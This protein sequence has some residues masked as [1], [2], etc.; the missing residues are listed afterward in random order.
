MTP[1]NHLEESDPL[2]SLSELRR[3]REIVY[4][5]GDDKALRQAAY[6]TQEKVS[7][8]IDRGIEK[9]QKM[10]AD[11]TAQ[12]E[13]N[14]RSE[15]VSLLEFIDQRVKECMEKGESFDVLDVGCGRG[16]FLLELHA[17][18]VGKYGEEVKKTLKFTGLSISDLRNSYFDANRKR[19][20]KSLLDKA[21]ID[22][23]VEDAR[24]L[25]DLV[26]ENGLG[27]F[28]LVVS[29]IAICYV[30]PDRMRKEIFKSI[31]RSL[32][33]GG[34]C[35][36]GVSRLLD[37]GVDTNYRVFHTLLDEEEV[38]IQNYL[39][40][41]WK[42]NGIHISIEHVRNERNSCVVMHRTEQP[43][44]APIRY[45]AKGEQMSVVE[46][47]AA[48]RGEKLPP[49]DAHQSKM[50][51]LLYYKC[52]GYFNLGNA[53]QAEDIN[54]Y[55]RKPI[56][57]S[58]SSPLFEMVL[59]F[60]EKASNDIRISHNPARQKIS[61]DEIRNFLLRYCKRTD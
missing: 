49:I 24:F 55:S 34:T 4:R 59:T 31:Y 46:W 6:G 43:F 32:K 1:I 56:S 22:Y 23:L 44:R 51:E 42:D 36:A 3:F 9:Y 39:N 11:F 47:A 38:F 33:L 2:P 13:I 20:T 45:D 27:P 57:A 14:G 15:S 53:S 28:D 37:T 5:A 60:L 54:E 48:L 50:I 7:Y 29:A 61:R 10:F 12:F 30:E 25:K 26:A 40:Q 41:F 58:F 19:P 17:Y 21:G 35:V 52:L 18:L 8:V 16:D